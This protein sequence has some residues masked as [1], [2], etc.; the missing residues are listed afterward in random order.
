[1]II[2]K[3]L[4]SYTFRF[5]SFY[6]A[7]LSVAVL[8]VLVL[9]YATF[10]YD[11]FHD[12]RDS[13]N[14]ELD[15]LETL[16]KRGGLDAVD[17]FVS[18]EALLGERK[19][20]YYLVV[21]RGYNKLAGNLEAWPEYREYGEGWLSFQLDILRWDG[22]AVDEGFLARS[23][24]LENGHHLLSARHYEDV[25]SSANLVGG[26]LIRS[27]VVTIVLGTIGGAIVAGANV[28]QLDNI[29]KSLQRIMSGD[30]SERINTD[31]QLGEMRELAFNLN[32]MLQRIQ[33]LMTGVRQVSDNIAHDLRTPLTRLRNHLAQLQDDLELEQQDTIQQLID[34]ADAL[35]LT[36]NSLLR[37]AH[38]ESGS[39]R[40]GF[41]PVD[42]KVIV[43]DVIELYEP[44]A[45]DKSIAI[46]QRLNNG[47]TMEGDRN[48]LFQ[49]FANLIDNAIKYT[50]AGGVIDIA[51]QA[52]HGQAVIRVA[53][54]G[55][56]IPG[57]D[58]GKVFRRFF[59]VEGSRSEQPGNGL[60]LSLV[61]AVIKLHGGNIRL[62]DHAPGLIVDVSLPL[63]SQRA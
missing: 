40:S 19:R 53:D 16:L 27:M 38:V 6:V 46:K 13:V 36:F 9:V 58:I 33:M 21:D 23:R 31:N 50:P 32:R 3:V 22:S 44:L 28:R 7:G 17:N 56:G 1:M 24:Q 34:E 35:L 5:M 11:Y 48:L 60:G 41:E 42:L 47:L 4:A 54:S 45:I 57:Q 26:A 61:E 39:R 55:I 10:S 62:S 18:G 29:N 12:L 30:L 2:N 25:A 43:L 15:H 52:E 49:A 37:I 14:D 20:V 63:E 51:L 8:I 59:R